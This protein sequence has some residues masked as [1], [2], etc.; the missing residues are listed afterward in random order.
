M[1]RE[2]P[3]EKPTR[4]QSGGDRSEK[5]SPDTLLGHAD[6]VPAGPAPEGADR[7]TVTATAP[8][9]GGSKLELALVD[10]LPAPVELPA[11]PPSILD[12]YECAG[13]LGRGGMGAVYRARDRRLQ[14]DVALK[15]VFG[16]D[17]EPGE[18]LLREA[19]SQARLDHPNACKVY[20]V[21]VA[22]GKRYIAM[23]LVVGASF[24]A[25]RGQTTLEEKLR[26]V[27]QVA[28]ALHEA[29]RLGLVHRDVKPSNIMVERAEDGSW[30]PFLMDFGIA[31]DIGEQGRTAT[32]VITGTPAFMAPE[33]VRGEIRA[34][35]RR[36]DVYSLGATLFD[37]LAGRPPFNPP[38]TWQLFDEIMSR[39]APP[40]R[41]VSPEVPEDVEAILVKCLEKE[42]NRRYD[43][44]KALGEDLQRFLDGDPVGARRLSTGYVLLRKARKHKALVALAG[45]AL[46]AVVVL[47]AVWIRG[48]RLA[49]EQADLS[50]ELGEAAKAME[51]FLRIAYGLPLHDIEHEKDVVRTRLQDIDGRLAAA[52]SM[53]EGPGHYALGRGYLALQEPDQALSHFRL[54]SAAGYAS[55]ELDYAMGLALGELCTRALEEAKRIE[56]PEKKKARVAA[57][58]AE[59][60][61]P[62]LQ[63]L[64]GSRGA[65]V[66]SAAYVEGVIALHEGK[67]EEA[68][69][70]AREASRKAPWLYEAKKLE[71]DA[72]FALG[73][74]F[75]H[76]AAFD[77]DRM[78][79]HFQLAAEAYG[80]ASEVARSDPRVH[81]GECELWAQVMNAATARRETLR[82]SFDKA[83]AACGRAI[84]ASSRRDVGHLKLAFV[85]A[86]FGWLSATGVITDD[87]G[88]V[89]EATLTQAREVMLRSPREPMAPYVMGYGL[90]AEASYLNNR[91]LDSLSSVDRGIVAYEQA[92][93][94]DP[95]FLWAMN[96]LGV[97]YLMKVQNERFHGLDPTA[98]LERSLEI[99]DRAMKLDPS[100]MGPRHGK[101][102]AHLWM[103]DY[104]V[105]TG[106]DPERDLD[107]VRRSVEDMRKLS[108]DWQAA[109]YILSYAH[110]LKASHDLDR[111][112]DPSAS[113]DEGMRCANELARLAPASVSAYEASGRLEMTRALYLLRRGEDPAPALRVAR[114]SFRQAMKATPWDLGYRVWCAR[115]EIL[116]LGWTSKERR[117]EAGDFEA[118]RA[119]L[120]PLLDRE[121]VDPRLYDA[122]AQIDALEA[123]W[124][125]EGEKTGAEK[126]IEHGLAMAEKA[127]ALNPR[128]ARALFTRGS[129]LLA[130]A[131]A[132]RE[133]AA[134]FAAARSAEGAFTAALRENPLLE[135]DVEPALRQARRLLGEQGG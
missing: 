48:K 81:E 82:S 8:V 135:R 98:S 16:D 111:G 42:P 100:F 115:V 109:D 26:I 14:R 129:L 63:H 51:V 30:R 123:A 85:Q 73:S 69:A 43:S 90:L 122:L 41:R 127:L 74:R 58:E 87:P 22:D 44:A 65:E 54:A 36:T 117:L 9:A 97:M 113:L 130:R 68:V 12:R 110:W 78:M 99:L 59:Y 57:I 53:G 49:A 31:R 23:Q 118:A 55:P 76:D 40:I 108:R 11:L 86:S 70:K 39:E 60:R 114:E 91:G 33:Q 27:R 94:L 37:V 64:R 4:S 3:A 120:L 28:L 5:A 10:V 50:R 116:H 80:V 96:D 35:D 126:A 133:R 7:F 112:L 1:A 29:H 121:R 67:Y 34:L 25:I 72:R 128:L 47:A 6:T 107:L 24:D 106:G 125:L 84:A 119:P 45:A 95:V 56:D 131:R 2:Q 18:R 66:E 21:G 19:R 89:I 83:K 104:L 17:S 132:A 93:R 46:V 124:R 20:E 105:D 134:R 52:G 77:I 75:R 71:G 62:A 32:G 61:E 79:E 102:R 38:N 15:F 103:A 88:E 92:I 13:I 101:I